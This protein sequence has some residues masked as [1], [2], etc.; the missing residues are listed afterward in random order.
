V[1]AAAP[2]TTESFKP[3]GD[4]QSLLASLT[5]VPVV[6]QELVTDVANRLQAGELNTPSAKEETV[7]AILGT[8]LPG[9]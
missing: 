2:E 8:T 6:R 7:S 3:T 4:I 9:A 5:Q 1:T